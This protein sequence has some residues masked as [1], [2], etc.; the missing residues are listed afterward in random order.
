[1]THSD[2][3]W[4]LMRAASRVI[5]DADPPRHPG[6]Y[7][8]DNDVL[9]PAL[10]EDS[11]VLAWDEGWR[12]LPAA[13]ADLRTHDDLYLP[14]AAA[15]ERVPL[16]VGQLG[17]SMDGFIA[18]ASGQSHYVTGEASLVHLH[19][20]RALSDCVIVGAGTV[21]ADDPRLTTR[22]VD[23]D[24]PVRVVLDPR[25]RLPLTHRVFSDAQASTLRIR[26]QGVPLPPQRASAAVEDIELPAPG[27]RLDLAAL[28]AELKS[29]GYRAILVE[30]GGITLSGFLAA[31][32]LDRLHIVV[33][34]FIM[35]E[36]RPGLRTP[37]VARL[38]DCLRPLPR[39]YA[40]GNDVLFDC[41]LRSQAAVNESREVR[42]IL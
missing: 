36:G 23:G 6:R 32:L 3:A 9:R 29:R 42:R 7:A 26:A 31:G 30:G 37:P 27:G 14:L 2:K 17:Q 35:G 15:R 25:L 16:V 12:F 39:I 1:M 38:Q 33:A 20:L 19:R 41:D 5:R 10:A 11:A 13:T 28:L 8:F 18:T 21:A 4:Q 24:N 22:L 40:L 34:P